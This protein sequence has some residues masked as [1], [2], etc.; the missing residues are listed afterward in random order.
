MGSRILSRSFHVEKWE[1]EDAED[2][3]L[4]GDDEAMEVDGKDAAT[5]VDHAATE[6]PP[7]SHDQTEGAGEE[8]EEEE[9]I[10]DPS[11]VAMVPLADALNARYGSENAKLFYE[12]SCL[13][14]VT[15]K[16]IASGDQIWNT[17]G[18]PPNSDLLRRYGHVD[19]VPLPQGGLG[20]PADIVEVRAD[21]VV[22]AANDLADKERIDWWLE[23]GGDDV[24]ILDADLDIP[25][26]MISL[27]KL[28]LLSPGEWEKARNKGK[29]PKP[30]VDI[31]VLG[32]I[33]KILT[34]RL[35][36]YHT[37]LQ[38]DEELLASGSSSLSVNHK[39]AI[40]VR[41]GEKRI[42]STILDIK[43]KEME[44]TKQKSAGDTKRKRTEDVAR[45][46]INSAKKAKR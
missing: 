21:L 1:S 36:E 39:N 38:H 7:V 29:P 12:E 18:D 9:D 17:Y 23:E 14:M 28:V 30:K 24:F 13:K 25:D 44:V 15:T 33:V 16:P 6:Q 5:G 31:E 22:A 32:I 37:T 46:A 35:K 10:E 8:E 3:R 26:T 41:I 45:K 27:I 20:N 19:L 34:Q 2:Q 42:L 40:N 4:V 43:S 11:D